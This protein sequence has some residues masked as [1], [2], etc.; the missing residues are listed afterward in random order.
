MY[1]IKIDLNR[2]PDALRCAVT[3][4]RRK[5]DHADDGRTFRINANW[6]QMAA[7]V[8]DADYERLELDGDDLVV[9]PRPARTPNPT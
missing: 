5:A 6:C 8:L 9:W 1:P 7:D 2:L 3:E 4:Y